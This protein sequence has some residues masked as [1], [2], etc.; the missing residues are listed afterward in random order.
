MQIAP[1]SVMPGHGGLTAQEFSLSDSHSRDLRVSQESVIHTVKVRLNEV[2]VRHRV[3]SVAK[4]T[5][6]HILIV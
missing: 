2:C 6:F 4:Y 5:V 1:L 3:P